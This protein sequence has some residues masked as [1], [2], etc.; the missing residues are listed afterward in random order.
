MDY[1]GHDNDKNVDAELSNFHKSQLIN[2]KAQVHVS[3]GISTTANPEAAVLLNQDVSMK[4][5]Q[6]LC[7]KKNKAVFIEN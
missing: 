3:F 6:K 1:N 4:G 2:S 7:K 5:N